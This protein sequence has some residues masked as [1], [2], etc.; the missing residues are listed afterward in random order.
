VRGV[1][2]VEEV[3]EALPSGVVF[4]KHYAHGPDLVECTHAMEYRDVRAPGIAVCRLCHGDEFT[5]SEFT[6][7]VKKLV[8]I[9]PKLR[10]TPAQAALF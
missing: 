8:R 3:W 1:K 6:R 4:V 9:A 5:T 10:E 2:G 7:P